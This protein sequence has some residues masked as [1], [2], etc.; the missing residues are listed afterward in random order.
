MEN[1][2]LEPKKKRVRK[3]TEE[4]LIAKRHY[5]D[6]N[7]ERILKRMKDKAEEKRKA[8]LEAGETPRGRGRPK[9]P[10]PVLPAREG[11]GAVEA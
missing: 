5:Y 8:M 7:R 4:D 6:E 11:S 1:N 3:Y 2:N 9:K 10:R